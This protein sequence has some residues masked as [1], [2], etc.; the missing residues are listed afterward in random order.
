MHMRRFLSLFS[1]FMLF[2]VFAFAQTRVV[3]GKVTDGKG[4]SIPFATVTETGIKNVVVA[5][6]DGNFSIKTKSSGSLTITASGYKPVT[7]S[8]AGNTALVIMERG[9]GVLEEVV[10]TAL[11]IRRQRKD[12]GYSTASIKNEELTQ[13]SP[14]NIANGLQGKVSGLNVTSINSGVF[15]DVKINLRGIRSLTGNNNPMFLL[16][17]VQT[18]L[19]FLSSINPQD[20][21]DVTIL[22]GASGAGIYGPDARNGVIVVTTKRGGS[23]VNPVISVGRTTQFS[24]ISF[25][26]E[27][28]TEF[29]SGGFGSYIPYENWSWGPRFDGSM[30]ALGS[31]LEGGQQQ[32]VP[33]TPNNSRKEFFN[34]GVINQTDVSFGVKDFY[35]SVQDATIKGIVPDDRNRR[36]GIRMNSSRTYGKFKAS[37]G[38]NY[39]QQ[40][41]NVFDD[42]GMA[43]YN[44]ANNVGLNDGLLNLIFNTPAHV[45]ITSYKNF[46][47]YPYASYTGYFNHYGLNPYI[48]LDNWRLRGVT[49]DIISNLDLN[50]KATSSLSFTWRLAGTIRN[51]ESRSTSKGQTATAN[52][53]NT[54]TPIPGS[55]SQS[56]TR[57]SRLSSEIFGNW[58]KSVN[59]FRFNVIAGHYLRES[60]QRNSNVGA[61]NLV[62]PELYNISNGVGGVTG[63]NGLTKTRLM[64]L[65]GSID[66]GYKGWVN[67]QFTGRNDWA[68]VFSQDNNS[69]FYPGVNASLVLTDAI[70]GLKTEKFLS[71]LK[72]KGSW[73]KTANADI[74]PYQTASTFSG[75]SAGFPYSVPGYTASNSALNPNLKPEFIDSKEVGLE[76]GFLR[77]RIIFEASAYSQN[78]TDQ[79]INVQL[80]NATGYTSAVVNAASFVNRGIEL[81]LKL[82]PLFNLG[83][84]RFDV[85][86]NAS[87]NT[88]EVKSIYA[89]L[90]RLAIGGFATAS[91]YALV[92]KPAFVFLA[93]DYLRDAQGRVI[94]DRNSGL[95]SVDPNLKEFGRTLPLYIVGV[96]PSFSY[97]GL[98]ISVVG[99]YRG[100][101]Y[102]YATIGSAMAWTGVSKATAQNGRERFVFPNSV[103]DNGTGTLVPNT[104]VT[105]NDFNNF[106]ISLYRQAQSNFIMKADSWRI[107]EL[108]LGYDFPAS[109]FAGQKMLKG[110]NVTFN[111]RNLQLWVP[112][113][114]QFT[115][116][117]FNFT[118][119]NTSGIS[120]NNI[121]PPTRVLGFNVT[122]T[123]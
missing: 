28:Q 116:P 71:F 45:P 9:E 12:L 70:P 117:D 53:P 65:Y 113:S 101:H 5:D 77:D 81:D 98:T 112:K 114:N 2:G 68:S 123:F 108:S 40:N 78:N 59:N 21:Q 46:K 122:A 25:F 62:V 7:V 106:Y 83:K 69:F 1:M 15:D 91:N 14:V 109:V 95:P 34:T 73:N 35:L 19:N 50:Y 120:T 100:G 105:I 23:N 24:S 54:N 103:Y 18:D 79:I 3:T 99:E 85:K 90:D 60:E 49:D 67:L 4:G 97:K 41:Y 27:F 93:A 38:I 55:V 6:G 63:G 111:A 44:A 110:L 11:G 74:N 94:V 22:K 118:Q 20:I 82:T 13:S 36:T 104:N 10:V 57:R 31:P 52:A 84:A 121:N 76:I 47:D 64:S 89:G 56:A 42:G 37:I 92:G 107:R 30:I 75:T 39:I 32:M 66:V 17:G 61:T 51:A 119:G 115:D 96:T 16:D 26:P 29:G 58:N 43:A 88:S 8:P 33:Y 80:S 86:A 72:V 48:A 87:Y 102:A